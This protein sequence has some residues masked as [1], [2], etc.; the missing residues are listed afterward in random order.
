MDSTSPSDIETL[1]RDA[2]RFVES[3]DQS[4]ELLD[5]MGEFLY[6]PNDII[7][8]IELGMKYYVEFQDQFFKWHQYQ[9]LH[10]EQNAYR[11]ATERHKSTGKKHR[12]TDEDG[13][14]IDIIG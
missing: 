13:H 8:N 11:T 10:N 7:E 2:K 14:I 3:F 1:L 4:L 12:I 5:L 9:T 6:I